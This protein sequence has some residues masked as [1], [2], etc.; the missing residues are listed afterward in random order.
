MS[1][2]VSF[3]KQFTIGDKFLQLQ[4]VFNNQNFSCLLFRLFMPVITVQTRFIKL[5][6]KF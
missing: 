3:N 5:W 1:S 2:Y 4:L 6:K